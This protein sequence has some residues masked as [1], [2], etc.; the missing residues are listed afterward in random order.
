MALSCCDPDEEDDKPGL[1]M[2]CG[3]GGSAT[4]IPLSCCVADKLDEPSINNMCL[5]QQQK[6][7][8]KDTTIS[9]CG[10]AENSKLDV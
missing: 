1:L 2:L 7:S 10:A 5:C 8:H 4:L 9:R 6:I 3:V